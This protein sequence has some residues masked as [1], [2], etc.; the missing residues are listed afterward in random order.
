[1]IGNFKNNIYTSIIVAYKKRKRCVFP[2]SAQYLKL[3]FDMHSICLAV[4]LSVESVIRTAESRQQQSG[5]PN[6]L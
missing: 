5:I 1:M 6:Y 2:V 4:N 3:Y